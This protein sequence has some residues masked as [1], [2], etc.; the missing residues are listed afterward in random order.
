MESEDP[1]GVLCE[2]EEETSILLDP[3]LCA[4]GL[5]RRDHGTADF[6]DTYR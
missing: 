4:N 5:P 2:Q 3:I 6:K 1:I